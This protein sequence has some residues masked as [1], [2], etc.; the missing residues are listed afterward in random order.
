MG[1]F[2]V[3]V[4]LTHVGIGFGLALWLARRL[5]VPVDATQALPIPAPQPA[6]P[7]P[8]EP[9]PPPPPREGDLSPGWL[10]K[11]HVVAAERAFTKAA[12]QVL[13]LDLGRYREQL[14][15]VDERLRQLDA[16]QGREALGPALAQLQKANTA[17]LADHTSALEQLQ[18][19]RCEPGNYAVLAERLEALMLQQAA[20][21]ESTCTNLSGLPPT[22]DARAARLLALQEVCRLLDLVHRLRDELNAVLVRIVVEEGWLES[23]DRRLQVD[24]VLQMPNRVGLAAALHTWWRHD[25]ARCRLASMAILGIE[26]LSTV[27]LTH[28]ARLADRLVAGVA[29][30][31]ARMLHNRRHAT[32]LARYNGPRLA[33]LFKDIGHQQAAAIVDRIRQQVAGTSFEHEGIEVQTTLTCAVTELLPQD[34]LHSPSER[35]ET[36]LQ[37]AHA[38]GGNCTWVESHGEL[39][40]TVLRDDS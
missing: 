30:F 9:P 28:G 2:V 20:Q 32:V 10:D 34:T 27:N 33:I 25:A 22:C 23:L 31:V 19:S 36:I 15:Q 17:Y 5:A 1:W 38:A 12:L 29:E 40:P 18:T 24:P 4:G 8:P 14:V 16:C 13:R 11:L 6:Q 21:I 26:R 37:R 3:L 7:S 39:R 35:L